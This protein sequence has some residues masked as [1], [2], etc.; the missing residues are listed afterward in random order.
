MAKKVQQL[1]PEAHFNYL[2][3]K[4]YPD[5]ELKVEYTRLRDIAQKRNK[6]LQ[7]AGLP[8][9]PY[10]FKKLRDISDRQSLI[11]NL[12][13]VHSFVA[14]KMSTVRGARTARKRAVETFQNKG[15]SDITEENYDKFAQFLATVK[16]NLETDINTP[17]VVA[18]FI[19][20]YDEKTA[21]DI[22]ARRYT[23]WASEV[24]KK[25]YY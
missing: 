23:R 9:R 12:V 21:V 6:R 3:L 16:E 25:K 24:D 11:S 20:N 8:A 18:F 13:D 5:K 15:F 17:Q 10:D 14:S 22:L 19:K 7:Q 1:I 4:K 2:A